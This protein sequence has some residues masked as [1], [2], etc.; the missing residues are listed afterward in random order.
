MQKC[1]QVSLTLFDKEPTALG[2]IVRGIIFSP[3][4]SWQKIEH[5]ALVCFELSTGSED[6]ATRDMFVWNSQVCIYVKIP[7]NF[8]QMD[9][10]ILTVVAGYRFGP[11]GAPMKDIYLRDNVG[12]IFICLSDMKKKIPAFLKLYFPLA[13]QVLWALL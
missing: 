6:G 11:S 8:S 10:F 4:N 5:S 7:I 3:A 1:A 12:F 2:L 9:S 13:S